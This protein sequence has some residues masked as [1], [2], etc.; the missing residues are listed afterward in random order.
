MLRVIG[1]AL[2]GRRLTTQRGESIRPTS[3]RIKESIFNILG[4]QIEGEVVLDLFA[5]TG[6]LGI[7]ALSR[8]ARKVL[9]VEKER[10]AVSLIQ[11]NLLMCGLEA[12]AEI[13]MSDVHRAIG[14]LHRRGELFD[15]ILMDPPYGRGFVAL[16]LRKLQSRRIY[17]ERSILVLQ[18]DR[19]EP[20]PDP[21]GEWNLLQQRKIGDTILSILTPKSESST[22]DVA[23]HEP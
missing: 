5:G 18:H 7:E 9:F 3:D 4:A 23:L 11:K 12:S 15:V 10:K 1:G 17:H 22:Q 6:N 13:L 8:G 20:L 16:T 2:R 14:V 21:V 19:R